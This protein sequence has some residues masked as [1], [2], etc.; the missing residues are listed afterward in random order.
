MSE[1]TDRWQNPTFVLWV[2]EKIRT[3]THFGLV[4][5]TCIG[6][7]RVQVVDF[8]DKDVIVRQEFRSQTIGESLRQAITDPT[9]ALACLT[10]GL[11]AEFEVTY[12]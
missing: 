7:Y 6:E 10:P 2:I 12:G 1:K 4:I 3:E 5:G 11:E 9:G 8:G